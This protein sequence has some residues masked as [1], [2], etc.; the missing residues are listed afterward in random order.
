MVMMCE[1]SCQLFKI[2]FVCFIIPFKSVYCTF[3]YK[4]SSLRC[5]GTS[6]ISCWNIYNLVKLCGE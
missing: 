4:H 5:L 2:L 3:K 1:K 6:L